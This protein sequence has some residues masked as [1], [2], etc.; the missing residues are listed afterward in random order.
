MNTAPDRE[1]L[2][3]LAY[4][5]TATDAVTEGDLLRLVASAQRF[6]ASVSVSGLLIYGDQGFLQ[7]IEGP[8]DAITQ[9]FNRI[10]TDPAHKDIRVFV[11]ER[12][13]RRLYPDWAMLIVTDAMALTLKSMMQYALDLRPCPLSTGQIEA[14]TQSLQRLSL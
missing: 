12:I 2:R 5:S 4:I 1:Q 9:V 7:T 8:N 3:C 11:D 10:V 6:N 13:T 14:A